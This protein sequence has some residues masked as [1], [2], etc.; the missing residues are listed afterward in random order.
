MAQV[1][2]ISSSPRKG[3]RK[4]NRPEGEFLAAFGL[5]E[6]AHAGDWHRQVSLLAQ[7]SI[8]SMREKG[9]EVSAGNFAE[10]ITTEDLDL[11]VLPVGCHLQLG[12][13]ELIVSQLGKICHHRCTIYHQAGDCVMPREGIFAVVRKGGTIRVGDPI[14]VSTKRSTAAAVVSTAKLLESSGS[15]LT[16]AVNAR[17]G[18]AFTRL[19]ALTAREGGG[20]TAILA[21]LVDTQAID[22]IVI[23]DPSGSQAMALAGWTGNT[24]RK[25]RYHRKKSIIDYCRQIDEVATL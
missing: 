20:L 14:T 6:D 19:D 3:M 5:N 7:E 9:L 15:A 25:N 8:D 18:S 13:V 24:Q 23:V 4:E 22:R 17:F 16:V 12:E 11:T 2:A 1:K 10:N 21:D